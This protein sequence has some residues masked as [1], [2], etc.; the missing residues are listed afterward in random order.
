MEPGREKELSFMDKQLE[1]FLQYLRMEKRLSDNTV[2]AYLSD[3]QHLV[4]FLK[5]QKVADFSLV[6]LS[7]I[8]SFLVQCQSSGVSNRS[9]LRKTASLRSFFN[10]LQARGV[11]GHNPTD[12]LYSP[13]ASLTL[14]KALSVA[15][16]NLLLDAPLPASPLNQRNLAMLHMLYAT[17]LRVSELVLLRVSAC[18]LINQQVR[19]M[20]KGN[21]E[22]LV[23][24]NDQAKIKLDIYLNQARAKILKGKSSQFVFVTGRGKPMSRNR[25]WQIIKKIA[26]GCGIKKEISPHVL[27][28]SFATHL[29]SG[30]ADLRAVQMLL[31]HSDISTTQIYTKIDSERLKSVHKQFHPRG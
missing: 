28:H 10:F 26:L 13:K 17:G 19:V 9:N 4:L 29:L 23:P 15:E 3:L 30:G 7:H 16:V 25:F 11:V 8:R 18:N 31:G 1:M 5:Q 6:T 22:R 12:K 24:F 20:G 27:R 2:V 21:K 14:P